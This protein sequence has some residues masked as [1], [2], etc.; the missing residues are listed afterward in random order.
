MQ[1]EVAVSCYLLEIKG[2]YIL[3]DFGADIQQ[4]KL[5]WEFIDARVTLA[6]FVVKSVHQIRN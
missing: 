4:G 2:Y 3:L 1:T 6:N 5:D